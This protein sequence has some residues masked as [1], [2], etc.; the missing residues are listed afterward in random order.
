MSEKRALTEKYRRALPLSCAAAALG[1]SRKCLD[2]KETTEDDAGVW[3]QRIEAI[4][5]ETP[6]YGYRK[7]TAALRRLGHVVNHKKVMRIMRETG[8]K[9]KR[10]K[11]KPR[12]T[13]SRHRLRT[14]PNMVKDIIP[15]FPHHVWA[16]DITYVRLP[17]GFCY[18]AIIIDVFTKRIVGWAI[19]LSMELPL[20]MEALER[21]LTKGVPHFHHS[22]RGGQYCATEYV[23][24][25][26]KLGVKVSMADTGV[27]VDNP[28]AESFN[29]TLK[30]EE[31]YLHEYQALDDARA[32][33]ED[34]IERVYHTKRLH[35]SLGY[36]T[37]EEFSTAWELQNK[38][39]VLPFT[40]YKMLDK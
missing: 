28:F 32:S 17:R 2:E 16:S 26:E 1:L 13:D 5:L 9:Q 40:H 14:F 8:L 34:F 33:I 12:T 19:A 20:V 11:Y 38:S 30:V 37:P 25:L 6:C 27:S 36:L 31:V 18:V 22:D 7:V 3:K 35:Q 29:R 10:R 23:G 21:A 15:A 4:L 24:T 39:R